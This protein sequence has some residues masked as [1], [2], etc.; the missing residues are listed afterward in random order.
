MAAGTILLRTSTTS[1]PTVR[2]ALHPHN[3][4]GSAVPRGRAAAHGMERAPALAAITAPLPSAAAHS[5]PGASKAGTIR[6]VLPSLELAPRGPDQVGHAAPSPS[7]CPSHRTFDP[8]EPDQPDPLKRRRESSPACRA[9]PAPHTLRVDRL[10]QPVADGD[11]R[12][13]PAGP[14]RPA[15]PTPAPPRRPGGRATPRGP[16]NPGRHRPP[17]WRSRARRGTQARA[18]RRPSSWAS[19]G[20]ARRR[21]S[22]SRRRPRARRRLLGGILREPERAGE[23]RRPRDVG[24]AADHAVGGQQPR[25]PARR[26]RS[27]RRRAEHAAIGALRRSSRASRPLHPAT[28]RVTRKDAQHPITLDLFIQSLSPFPAATARLGAQLH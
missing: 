3:G 7:R 27:G 13:R 11:A 8:R 5:A 12:S 16:R 21:G 25:L 17:T 26:P 2:R 24:A 14:R 15:R 28:P 22:E 20:I 23:R 4:A 9:R 6:D 18:A 10:E 1:P 19:A